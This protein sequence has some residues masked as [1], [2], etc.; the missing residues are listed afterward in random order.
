[1]KSFLAQITISSDIERLMLVF[2]LYDS[3]LNQ[4]SKATNVQQT[5]VIQKESPIWELFDA[6]ST[7]TVWRKQGAHKISLPPIQFNP[8]VPSEGKNWL[9]PHSLLKEGH[10][11]RKKRFLN[12]ITNNSIEDIKADFGTDT[13]DTDTDE[14]KNESNDEED[15]H[16][17][18]NAGISFES[19]D[20]DMPED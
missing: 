17:D 6:N 12:R 8:L 20:K 15:D 18:H 16:I 4:A 1:M 13:S 9:K 5:V 11:K 7:L 3:K 10:E 14:N 2:A 19:A